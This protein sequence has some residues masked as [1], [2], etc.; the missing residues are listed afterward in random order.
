MVR[1]NCRRIAL[2][3]EGKDFLNESLVV[4]AVGPSIWP[5]KNGDIQ[6][7]YSRKS[8]ECASPGSPPHGSFALG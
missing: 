3:V 7:R 1:A 8:S 2:R 5:D 6:Y 4:S